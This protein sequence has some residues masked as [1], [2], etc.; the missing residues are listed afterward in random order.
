M[1]SDLDK[2]LSRLVVEPIG[3]VR[4]SLATKVEAARQPR[5]AQG[6]S[7]H[8]ELFPGRNFEHALEDL[9]RWK[10]IWVIFWFHHNPGWRPKVLPPRSTSG[11]KGV[12]ATRSPHRPNPIGL[13][14]VRLEKIEGLNVH[15]LD[16]DIL[17]GTPVLDLKPY[18]AYTDSHP[19]AGNGWLD[20]QP[21]DPVAAYAV[22]F[23]PRAAEQAHWI[24]TRTGLGIDERIRSTL[25]LG[26]EPHPYRRIR[27]LDDGM[28]LAVKEWRV[29]FSV[30]GREVRVASIASGFREAQLASEA[31][32]DVLRAHREFRQAWGELG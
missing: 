5:A 29:R 4:T 15:I 31:D 10:L 21:A 27:R 23:T 12:F 6:A 16:A 14:V 7:A 24:E 28:Q 8:I 11:R 19:D 17:D 20:D 26:P 9:S 22:T 25:A 32:D 30:E 1:S 13:S 18:V 3:I 2:D